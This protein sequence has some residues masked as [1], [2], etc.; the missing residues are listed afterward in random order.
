MRTRSGDGAAFGAFPVLQGSEHQS[1]GL[2]RMFANVG[3]VIACAVH[4]KSLR[5]LSGDRG[6]PVLPVAR[7]DKA[8]KLGFF[9]LF[10][11]QEKSPFR[12]SAREES[13]TC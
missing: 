12:S 5:M 7:K 8:L 6:R 13:A 11:G 10:A 4:H 9:I 1:L 3:F 2:L